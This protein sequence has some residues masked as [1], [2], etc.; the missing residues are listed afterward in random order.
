MALYVKHQVQA[1]IDDF[2]AKAE[3]RGYNHLGEAFLQQMRN[4][5]VEKKDQFEDWQDP[6]TNEAAL[7]TRMQNIADNPTHTEQ[8][9]VDIA[10]ICSFLWNIGDDGT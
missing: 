2:T 3:K 8:N 1:L 7:R 9:L 5:F 6:I 4:R 10:L